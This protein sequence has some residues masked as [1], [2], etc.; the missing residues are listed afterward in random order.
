MFNS[1][2]LEIADARVAEAEAHIAG[3]ESIIGSLR[4]QNRPVEAAEKLLASYLP[5][6]EEYR[7]QRDEIAAQ[8]GC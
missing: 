8:L 3:L 5:I 4:L 7:R 6:L 1:V 2:Q